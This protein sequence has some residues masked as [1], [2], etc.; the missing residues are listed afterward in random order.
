M[1]KKR[2]FLFILALSL[3]FA[4][5]MACAYFISNFLYTPVTAPSHGKIIAPEFE[6]YFIALNKS[7]IKKDAEALACDAQ[8]IGAGGFVWGTQEYY[9][10]LSSG[11]ENKN[12]ATLVQNNLSSTHGISSEIVNI[13]FDGFT[14]E[15]DF[16]TEET[17]VLERALNIYQTAY[18]SLYDIAIS[19]DTGVYNEISA[20][21]AVNSAHANFASV[22]ADY[23]TLFQSNNSSA[24]KTLSTYLDK[25]VKTC[26]KLCSALPV[27][28]GQ[29]YAS[30][31]KYRYI[32][33]L[34]MYNSLAQEFNK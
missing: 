13:K 8:K 18:R 5:G 26:E 1:T 12:D 23:D 34:S 4:C 9:Y 24:L 7:Q 15:G 22:K 27:N 14:L 25:G 3:F 19:V 20:R 21:L 29:T 6:V 17:K 2:K 30:L 16:S 28:E 32:E 10:V 33:L 11:F 31:I